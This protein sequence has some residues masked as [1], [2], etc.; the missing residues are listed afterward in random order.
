M[1]PL[2][3]GRMDSHDPH[4]YTLPAYTI[5]MHPRAWHC[6]G[7]VVTTLAEQE[8]ASL[9][10]NDEAKADEMRRWWAEAMRP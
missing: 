6:N 9:A 10:D 3:C 5:G 2:R 4:D 1:M 7:H 8:W